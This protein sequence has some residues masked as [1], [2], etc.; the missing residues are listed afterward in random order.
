[1]KRTLSRWTEKARVP[2]LKMTP[3]IDVI[4]LLL[5]FFVLTANFNEIEM[6]LRMNLAAPGTGTNVPVSAQPQPEVIHIRAAEDADGRTI[7][8][9]G[10]VACADEGEL[11]AALAAV[12]PSSTAV[13]HPIETSSVEQV[14]D[15][16]GLCRRAGLNR[17]Q[18]AAK[19]ANAPIPSQN[20]TESK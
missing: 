7:W 15:L 10:E 9:V 16:Y 17:V 3:M 18:F 6:F 14:L 11:T 12:D 5:V 13:I 19:R 1:M 20:I 2:E 8:S 4:F